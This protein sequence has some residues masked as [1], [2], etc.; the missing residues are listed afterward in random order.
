M[1]VSCD[2]AKETPYVDNFS[3]IDKYRDL[4]QKYLDALDIIENQEKEKQEL[5]DLFERYITKYSLKSN[6]MIYTKCWKT[7]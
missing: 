6:V 3:V 1:L 2:I 4:E 7:F 5:L